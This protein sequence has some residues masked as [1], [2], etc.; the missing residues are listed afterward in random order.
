MLVCREPGRPV[1]PDHSIHP[2]T[3][4]HNRWVVTETTAI[5]VVPSNAPSRTHPGPTRT[6]TV[7]S[8]A[9][10]IAILVGR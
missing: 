6:M 8:I 9:T 7:A 1:P 10:I 4:A 5:S 2:V 3:G